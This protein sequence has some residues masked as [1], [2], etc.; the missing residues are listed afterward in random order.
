[1]DSPQLY[2]E[3]RQPAAVPREYETL[4]TARD[5]R[6]RWDT[7]KG[8]GYVGRDDAADQAVYRVTAAGD[9]EEGLMVVQIMGIA[10]GA[11]VTVVALGILIIVFSERRRY[12]AAE[13]SLDS[14]K[15]G[16]K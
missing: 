4:R 13:P 7:R 3:C 1:M 12:S 11:V 16:E 2:G 10:V 9:A 5:T 8:E 15:V 6:G 14:P